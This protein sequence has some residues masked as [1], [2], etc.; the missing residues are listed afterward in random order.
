MPALLAGKPC[1]ILGDF[2]MGKTWFLRY[3]L[4]QLAGETPRPRW[5]PLYYRLRGFKPGLGLPGLGSL[6]DLL[7]TQQLVSRAVVIFLAIGRNR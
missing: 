3:M 2:G 7:V 1:I 6:L 5:I 4:Y